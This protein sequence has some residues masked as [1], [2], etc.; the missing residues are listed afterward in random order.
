[1]VETLSKLNY[2]RTS[3]VHLLT[4]ASVAMVI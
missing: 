4:M 1:M 3:T 2:D